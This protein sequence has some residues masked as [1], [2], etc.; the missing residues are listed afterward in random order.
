MLLLM[1]LSIFVSSTL[2]V[3]AKNHLTQDSTFTMA[4]AG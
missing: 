2:A 3:N 1:L 4:M